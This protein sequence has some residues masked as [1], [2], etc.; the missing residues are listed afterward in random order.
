MQPPTRDFKH[1]VAS[2]IQGPSGQQSSREIAGR[3]APRQILPRPQGSSSPSTSRAI[4]SDTSNRRYR[5]NVTVACD[6]CKV[7]RVK[8][9]GK[10]PCSR[11]SIKSLHC[12]YDQGIDG[13]RGRTSSSEVQALSERAEQYQ[14][15]FDL[16]RTSSPTVACNI[17]RQIRSQKVEDGD[18]A[19]A[20]G[21]NDSGLA[22]VLRYAETLA[23]PSPSPSPRLNGDMPS[24]LAQAWREAIVASASSSSVPSDNTSTAAA[25]EGGSQPPPSLAAPPAWPGNAVFDPQFA[26]ISDEFSLF[27]FDPVQMERTLAPDN[28]HYQTN[29]NTNAMDGVT[30]PVSNTSF[31]ARPAAA[32]SSTYTKPVSATAAI[33]APAAPPPPTWHPN[34]TTDFEQAHAWLRQ[35]IDQIDRYLDSNFRR[36]KHDHNVSR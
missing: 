24:P 26:T 31:A 16:L 18:C 19:G 13:R 20:D 7:K 6:Q 17:L 9:S 30:N 14:R 8:C 28:E 5:T 25:S 32:A 10:N 36:M 27:G 29:T 12:S 11:C 3:I 21:A 23:S 4:S 35:D 33:A 1:T 2:R 15:V 22:N 34:T